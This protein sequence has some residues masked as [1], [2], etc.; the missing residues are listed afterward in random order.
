MERDERITDYTGEIISSFGDSQREIQAKLGNP[1][2]VESKKV[3]NEHDPAVTDT[4]VILKYDGIDFGLFVSGYSDGPVR[5]ISMN[6]T[7]KKYK[8]KHLNIGDGMEKIRNQLG[9]PNERESD[10]IQYDS[11]FA[12]LMIYHDKKNI[13]TRVEGSIFLD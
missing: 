2:K 5:V 7:S 3:Q 9:E 11:D 12:I 4:I 1:V 13:V 6:C 8:L 10:Y